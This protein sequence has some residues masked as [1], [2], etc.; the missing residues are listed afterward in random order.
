MGRVPEL[1]VG[2]SSPKSARTTGLAII[3]SIVAV[4]GLAVPPAEQPG[5]RSGGAEV[6]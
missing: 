5:P 2:R 4:L 1:C 3:V 6:D